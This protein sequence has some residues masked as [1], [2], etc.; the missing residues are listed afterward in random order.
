VGGIAGALTLIALCLWG[1]LSLWNNLSLRQEP[2]EFSRPAATQTLE[3]GSNSTLTKIT[4]PQPVKTN[5]PSLTEPTLGIGSTMTGKNGMTLLYVPAGEFTMG[6]EDG[7]DDEKPVHTVSLEAFWIDQTEVTN[8]MFADFINEQGNQIEGDV[9]WVDAGDSDV[10]IHLEGDI[11]KADEGYAEHPVI[12]VSWHGAN[13]YCSWADR[14][15][16]TE[17]E[18]EKAARGTDER[19]YPWGN[20]ALSNSLLNYNNVIGDT[21]EVGNYPAGASPYGALDMAGNVWEWVD[22]WYDAYPGNTE[23]NSYFGKTYRVLRGGSWGD[24]VFNV[25]S[26]NHLGLDPSNAS[27]GFGFRCSRSH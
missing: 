24:N 2:T 25:R 16:P 26:A 20:D 15:L 11:W 14:R 18:W 27:Y 4:T 19:V 17:A 6:S 12:E 21:T 5:T 10:R 7:S 22:D 1:S 13:A 9:T 3:P 8:A 23:S